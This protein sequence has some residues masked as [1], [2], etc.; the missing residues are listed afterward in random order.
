MKNVSQRKKPAQDPFAEREASRYANPIPSREYIL[1]YLQEHGRPAKLEDILKVL[2]LKDEEAQEALRRRLRAM[3]RDGQLIRNRRG[4]YGL[5]KKM[6]LI[7]GVVVG[8]RDGYGFV[9]PDDRGEDL[10]L[11]GREMRAVFDGDRV[12]VRVANIDRRGRREGA[13]V[14][15]LERNTQQIVGRF[16]EEVGANFV[17][18]DHKRLNQDILIPAQESNG[19]NH[20]Q[21][22]LVDIIAQPSLR[23]QAIGRVVKVLGEHMAPG[24]EIDV[25][26]YAHGLPHVWPDEVLDQVKNF[27]EEISAADLVDRKDL[28]HLPF[29]TIDGE[30]ARDFDDAVYCLPE[31]NS[32]R[33]YVAIAD[34]SHYV[35]ADSPLDTEAYLRGNSVYFPA[36]VIPMLPEIL[37]NGLCSLK[38]NVDRL[39]MVC[40]MVIGNTGKI[41]RF[42]FYPSVIHSIARMTY[43]QATDILNTQIEERDNI[44]LFELYRLYQVLRR[45]RE[46]RG[47]I[48]FETVETQV[49]FGADRKIEQIVPKPRTVAHKIIE[50]CMLAAN[51]AAARFLDKNKMPCL[52][53]VHL[54]PT[55]DKLTDVRSFLKELGLGLRGGKNPKPSDFAMLL[56][57]IQGRVDFDQIQTILLRSL[58]QAVYTSENSGHFG[59]AY[60]AY[61]HFTS[62]I[63][64]YPDLIIHRAIS[65]VLKYG[66]NDNFQYNKNTMTNYG[67][68]CSLTER[69]ADDATRAALDW[70]KCEFMLNKIGY[71][72]E[73]RITNI[74]GF[75]MFVRLQNVYVEGLIHISALGNDYYHFEPDKQ[76]MIG[77][78]T[79]T[80]YRL[81]D[82]LRVKVAKVDLD[83]KK[84]D[85]ELVNA[86]SNSHS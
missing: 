38:P 13:I 53:R 34:V 54:G 64:R 5:V 48:D 20:G 8:H 81:G 12:L 55:H 58:S 85:F 43:T 59:L 33:L 76:R 1:G 51:V 21:F 75:G 44:H 60:D 40:E 47:A 24:M 11:N 73:G 45:Q 86:G 77:E 27:S 50:E 84:I 32:W 68:H 10:F 67:E 62:P 46:T 19:A 71:E 79:N 31:G 15:V 74:T 72:Y 9:V 18:P 37:S 57:E 66:S 17:V 30:D 16:F 80:C 49:I 23:N 28:R 63:R 14:E 61:T 4:A 83:E 7:R 65:H 78:R 2:Q 41:R 25:A 82:V 39:C 70:L 56:K 69:R 52:W 6:H 22:V 35:E 36:R 3:E 42:K 26:I 29:V